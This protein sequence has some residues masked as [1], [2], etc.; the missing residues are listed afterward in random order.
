MALRV[1][2]PMKGTDLK[3][4]I[5]W[6]QPGQFDAIA[7]WLTPQWAA[8]P[9]YD[10]CRAFLQILKGR[11]RFGETRS[12]SFP[13]FASVHVDEPV[14]VA[15]VDFPSLAGTVLDG[16]FVAA[17]PGQRAPIGITAG[18]FN[19]GVTRSRMY[20]MQ[21][22]RPTFYAFDVPHLAGTDLTGMTYDQRRAVLEEVVA[23]VNDRCP[24]AGV[25]LVPQIPATAAAIA[26][27]IDGG[28]EGVMLKRRAGRYEPAARPGQRSRDW[29]KVKAMATVDVVLTGG[30]TPGDNSRT[31]T[32]GSVE[33]AVVAEDG[34]WI[35]VGHCAVKPELLGAYTPG[36][37][38]GLAGTVWEVM[39]AGVTT[40]RKLRHPH[41]IRVRD[42]KR[43]EWCPA[44]QLD[45][46][47]AAA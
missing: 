45:A 35:P 41:M 18:W 42:D 8:E 43:P 24:D 20:R 39:A 27:Q 15:G 29:A 31:G 36:E 10:G 19:S 12:A 26:A 14:T 44:G 37:M 16:E 13:D 38:P 30:W 32:V 28:G 7:S 21:F 2:D 25:V 17:P 46:L 6:G 5:A 1:P 11:S 34:A 3:A 33:I 40:G 22:G 47:P 23:I 9:K 4:M